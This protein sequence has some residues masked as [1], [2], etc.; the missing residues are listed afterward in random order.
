[1]E[2]QN[3]VETVQ[4][5]DPLEQLQR[6]Q[7]NSVP[8]EKFE[9]LQSDYAKL[10]KAYASGER[11]VSDEATE[12]SPEERWKANC[13]IIRN[14]KKY[15]NITIA[16]ALYEGDEYYKEKYGKSIF[17]SEEGSI[18]SGEERVSEAVNNIIKYCLEN[19]GEDND[20]FTSFNISRLN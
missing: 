16:R 12:Q 10:F 15:D 13:E 20:T 3:I 8:K 2:D 18:S 14:A 9:K 7:E 5:E 6:I 1:M 17:S 11:G 19:A 4:E